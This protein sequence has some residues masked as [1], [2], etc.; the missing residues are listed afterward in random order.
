MPRNER[1]HQRQPEKREIE[2]A[3]KIRAWQRTRADAR[4]PVAVLAAKLGLSTKKVQRRLENPRK[5]LRRA[6]E[7]VK[8]SNHARKIAASAAKIEFTKTLRA[9]APKVAE[10]LGIVTYSVSAIRKSQKPAREAIAK[11]NREI[12]AQRSKDAEEFAA[13]AAL[14]DDHPDAIRQSQ[15]IWYAR[16]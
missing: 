3:A 14:P 8:L 7:R 11:R 16:D 13:R 12:K 5:R 6:E 1:P 10:K 4:C 2:I 15:P 9:P